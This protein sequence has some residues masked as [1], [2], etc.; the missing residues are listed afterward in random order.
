MIAVAS[1]EVMGFD[2]HN[3]LLFA[4]VMWWK[5]SGR[6]V[7][8]KSPRGWWC[9]AWWT[10]DGVQFWEYTPDNPRYD[11]WIPPPVYQGHVAVTY[12]ES[13]P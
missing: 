10:P 3:C 4:V 6:I 9:H 8:R 13:L 7:L 5:Y 12:A 2:P 11:L 1:T